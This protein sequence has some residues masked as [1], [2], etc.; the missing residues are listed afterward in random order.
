MDAAS[1]S[2]RPSAMASGGP[3]GAT[4]GSGGSP[5]MR[6]ARAHPINH[7]PTQTSVASFGGGAGAGGG[8]NRAG[9]RGSIFNDPVIEDLCQL[10]TFQGTFNPQ[11]FVASLSQRQISRSKVDPGPFDPRPF[12]RTFESAVESLTQIRG[13]VQTHITQFEASVKV[14]ENAYSTKLKELSGSFSSASSSFAALEDRISEVGRTAVRIG[15]QL[16]TIHRQKSHA[17][18]AYDLIEYYYQFARGDTTKLD[19]LK[20]EGGREGRVKVAIIARRLQAISKEVDVHGSQKTQE[21]VD[22]YCERF[23][24]DMLKLFDRAYRESDPKR[25]SHIAKVL[26][27]FNGGNS[28]VQIYVNQHDFFISKARVQEA[29]KIS[30]SQIWLKM[31]DPDSLPPKSEPSLSTLFDEIRSTVETEAQII[32]AVFPN[33]LIVMQ[34]FLQRVFAQS[35]QGYV[36]VLMDKASELGLTGVV[37]A[38]SVDAGRP[39]TSDGLQVLDMY[40]GPANLAYLRALHMVRSCSLSLVND[41]KVYDIRGSADNSSRNNTNFSSENGPDTVGTTTG[42]GGA[43]GAA[44]SPLASM[45]DQAVEELFVPY[46]ESMKYIDRESKNL[47]E[48][49]LAYLTRFVNMHRAAAKTKQTTLFD[50]VR[51][52]LASAASST[53]VSQNAIPNSASSAATAS[54]TNPAGAGSNTATTPSSTTTT[55]GG[56]ALASM[57]KSSAF[58]KFSGFVDRARGTAAASSAAAA[59]APAPAPAA[60]GGIM[61]PPSTAQSRTTEFSEGGLSTAP[62]SAVAAC[63]GT[64]TAAGA[65]VGGVE[66]TGTEGGASVNAG[67]ELLSLDVAERLLR[68]HAEAIGRCVELSAQAD[69][70]KHIFALFKVLAEA[71]YKTYM[72]TALESA[73]ALVTSQETRGLQLPDIST[74]LVVI[75]QAGL[76]AELWSQYVN[77]AVLPLAAT[78]VTTRREMI[79]FNSGH[80]TRVESKCDEILQ[81]VTDNIVAYLAARLATQ[82]RT[83]YN[84]KNDDFAFTRMNTEPCSA[85]IEAL[86]KVQTAARANLSGKNAEVFLSEVGVTFHSLML[87]HLKKFAVSATGGLMLTKDLAAYQDAI[88]GFGISA[89]VDRFEML[90]QLGNLFIVQPSVL[91]SYMREGHLASIDEA[92]LRPYL[93]RRTDYARDVRDITELALTSSSSSSNMPNPLSAAFSSSSS[94]DFVGR[95]GGSSSGGADADNETLKARRLA[96]VMSDME[97]WAGV[98]RGGAGGGVG[99]GAARGLAVVGEEDGPPPPPPK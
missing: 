38:A 48:L 29:Q 18:E 34:T 83:D 40:S 14:A 3:S 5:S 10:S 86:S 16:E 26:Q 72:D 4:T 95:G 7:T 19:K 25:M 44:H 35:I 76:F 62:S 66:G 53:S 73:V 55:T 85:C 67:E 50:R 15:E 39:G 89:L 82:K 80:A 33:P 6:P 12:I 46:M 56:S 42:P 94:L 45:L 51:T 91:K 17:S 88:A 31:T 74:P 59:A 65:G 41:L 87:D 13:S 20:K 9:S 71:F 24:R 21:A 70:P 61:S 99:G 75:R 43:G 52:G 98:E 32:T 54:S 2:R 68:W 27:A 97:A 93:L 30:E 63:S 77:M 58:A 84:P 36:E 78:S 11:D 22:H 79:I 47:T 23:E 28:C 60:V 81:R 90:R 57:A 49:Y 37:A 64:G 96:K 69:V 8:H 92:L 1:P